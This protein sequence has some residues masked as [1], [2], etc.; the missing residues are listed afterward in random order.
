MEEFMANINDIAKKTGFSKSTIS[1]YLNQGSVSDSAKKKI[2]EAIDEIGYIPN[3]YARNLKSSRTN[4]IGVIIPNFIGYTKNTALNSINLYLKTTP[5]SML[6]AC[7]NDD[8]DEEV[9]IIYEMQRLN[10]NGIIL[11][12]SDLTDKHMEAINNLSM[13]LV[14]FGQDLP[15]HTSIFAD[16][17]EA[18]L[19]MGSYIKNLNHEEISYFDVGSYDHAVGKRFE[20]FFDALRGT[21]IKLNH[22][23][24]DFTKKT[25]YEKAKDILDR[26][27]STLYLGATDNI[28]FGIIEA[29]REKNIRIP[30]DI[31]VAG[32]GNY[33]ISSLI[34]PALTT[35][36]FPYEKLG[37]YAIQSLIRKIDGG[38]EKK[39]QKTKP[40]LI[41]RDS[42]R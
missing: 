34:N 15:S 5:Y 24:F 25:A 14:I 28:A 30:E 7:S 2:K 41:L 21:S 42:L 22:H 29:L 35:V 20:G 19:L 39:I 12:A 3:S 4:T 17:Y 37:E 31:S 16:D 26:E 32:F 1:R 8:M 38:N 9:R 36:D 40:K 10:V 27:N 11:F 33:E 23:R 6:I 18:G 13:P